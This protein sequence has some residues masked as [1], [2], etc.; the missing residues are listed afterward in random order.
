[1]GKYTKISIIIIGLA[2]VALLLMLIP[3]GGGFLNISLGVIIGICALFIL[4]P[5]GII[6]SLVSVIKERTLLSVIIFLIFLSPVI[7]YSITYIGEAIE[8]KRNVITDVELLDAY[9]KISG[10]RPLY[11]LSSQYNK[12]Y[13]LYLLD[14]VQINSDTIGDGD[15]LLQCEKAHLSATYYQLKKLNTEIR[16]F[17]DIEIIHYTPCEEDEYKY[18]VRYYDRYSYC[19]EYKNTNKS[20]NRIYETDDIFFSHYEYRWRDLRHADSH[21]RKLLEHYEEHKSEIPV[22]S[23][24]KIK[25]RRNHVHFKKHDDR[26]EL[27]FGTL[28]LY[29]DFTLIAK[30]LQEHYNAGVFDEHDNYETRGGSRYVSVKIGESVMKLHLASYGNSLTGSLS[31]QPMMEQI[32]EDFENYVADSNLLDERFNRRDLW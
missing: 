28:D 21:Y 14:I 23:E 2:I 18:K 27:I 30:Y 20:Y 10:N 12:Y 25:K 5:I 13:N 19:Y 11:A 29:D 17:R 16:N 31:D 3:G 22:I 7:V 26:Y 4:V 1:M 15:I 6:V 24:E 9:E 32:A 8:N